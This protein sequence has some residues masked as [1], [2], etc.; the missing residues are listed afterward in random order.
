MEENNN[1]D[2]DVSYGALD[3]EE[4]YVDGNQ[5]VITKEDLQITPLDVIKEHAKQLGQELVDP[6][7]NCKQCYGRGY[8]GRDS[9][10]KAPLPCS[11]IQPNFND[12][13]NIQMYNRTRKVSRKERRQMARE[14]KKRAKRG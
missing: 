12:P 4:V 8:I 11:C 3:T 13:K 7:K 9:E 2:I 14:N 6:N 1:L 5:S 10:S